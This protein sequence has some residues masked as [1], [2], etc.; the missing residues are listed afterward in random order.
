MAEIPQKLWLELTCIVDGETHAVDHMLSR[1]ALGE[2]VFKVQPVAYCGTKCGYCDVLTQAVTDPSKS[3]VTCDEC[4][5][6]MR[7]ARAPKPAK[8]AGI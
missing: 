5:Q 6:E 7:K 8:G 1:D 2:G 3:N 4:R